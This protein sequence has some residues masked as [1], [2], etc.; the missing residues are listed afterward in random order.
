MTSPSTLLISENTSISKY[1]LSKGQKPYHL[2][3]NA[4]NLFA[5]TSFQFL[6]SNRSAIWYSFLK[7]I[8]T[9]SSLN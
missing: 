9:S 1:K 5:D 6:K 7:R 4:V 2:G 3:T 8:N